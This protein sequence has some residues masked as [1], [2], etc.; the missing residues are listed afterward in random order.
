M[1]KFVIYRKLLDF[2]KISNY[3]DYSTDLLKM[4]SDNIKDIVDN[5]EKLAQTLKNTEYELLVN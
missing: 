4:N 3:E 5:Y 1:K 2:L